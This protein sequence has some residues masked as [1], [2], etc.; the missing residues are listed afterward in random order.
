MALGYVI[1]D[2][3]VCQGCFKDVANL[4]DVVGGQFHIMVVGVSRMGQPA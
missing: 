3:D 1:G 2:V 4:R